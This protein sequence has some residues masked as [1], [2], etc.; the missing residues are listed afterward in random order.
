MAKYVHPKLRGFMEDTE[1]QAPERPRDGNVK[2]K[3]D[4]FESRRQKRLS[5]RT[6]AQNKVKTK[7]TELETKLKNAV[8]QL[9]AAESRADN[10]EFTSTFRSEQAKTDVA[11]ARANE[12][13]ALETAQAAAAALKQKTEHYNV[14]EKVL[15]K[16]KDHVLRLTT[17][18]DR[19]RDPDSPSLEALELAKAKEILDCE[20]SQARVVQD[21][22]RTE[23]AA[24]K[25]TIRNK[26]LD[27]ERAELKSIMQA[28]EI[29]EKEAELLTYRSKLG[30]ASDADPKSLRGKLMR[31]LSTRSSS[32]KRAQLRE[33]SKREAELLFEEKCGQ[34]SFRAEHLAH[35]LEMERIKNQQLEARISMLEADARA[36]D[37]ESDDSSLDSSGE[38]LEDEA[39]QLG[40]ILEEETPIGETTM[41]DSIDE[42]RE[43]RSCALDRSDVSAPSSADSNVITSWV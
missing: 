36:R 9:A 22:Q 10:A 35:E 29:T 21:A 23:I 41:N 11:A 42:A 27:M 26:N 33:A 31:A 38:S 25:T 14:L 12:R 1:N 2:Q 39:A 34:L 4:F 15:I 20:L 5:M 18:L 30:S 32:A 6:I 8:A 19:A 28:Y 16:E 17:E 37:D 40:K 13:V 3:R 43:S 24:L 7:Y